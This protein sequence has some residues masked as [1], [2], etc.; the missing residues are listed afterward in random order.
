MSS[1]TRQQLETWIKWKKVSGRVL[2]VGGS[3]LPLKDRIQMEG[4]TFVTVLDLENPH[5]VKVRPKIVQDLNLD[6]ESDVRE[7][8]DY[9]DYA[10]CLEVT[11]YLWNPV[12]ALETINLMM[13]QGGKLFISFHFIYPVHNPINQ[14]YLRYTRAGAMKI[15]Q[16]TGFKIVDI[17]SRKGTHGLIMPLITKE[18]MRPAQ[19]YDFHDDVG[20]LIVAEKL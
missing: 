15:L 2:D 17:S 3:Q 4:D 14:D 1:K 8:I 13:K 11:E 9:F 6:P 20:C 7:F 5:E 12:R 19:G 10:V 18:Q 16:Q